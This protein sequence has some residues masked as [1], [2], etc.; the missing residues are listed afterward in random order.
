MLFS[1]LLSGPIISFDNPSLNVKGSTKEST[2]LKFWS[3][4]GY[5]SRAKNLLRTAKIINQIHKKKVPNTYKNLILLPGVGDYTAKAILGIAFNKPVMP[6]DSNIERIIS[7]IYG[8]CLPLNKI[9]KEVKNKSERFISNK[10]SNELIQAFMDYGSIICVP[11]NPICNN[12]I[13]KKN[14]ISHKKNIQNVV[15]LKNNIY[16]NKIKKYTRAYVLSNEKNEILIRKR[17]SYGMLP[18]MIEVPND[19]WVKN[20]KLLVHD[21]L[22]V[23]LINKLK[24]IGSVKYSFSHF[25]LETD[26]FFVKISKKRYPNQKWINIKKINKSGLPTVMKKI[27]QTVY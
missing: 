14:C 25:D 1:I 7:R 15:P 17:S 27:V 20:K 19:D 16:L 8:L 10:F 2:I 9:K 5:Y 11:K 18:S 6:I 3:G 12:C 22:A 13:I 23:K 24:L 26:V 21:D 4:L